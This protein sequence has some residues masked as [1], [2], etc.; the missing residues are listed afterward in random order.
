M[1][2]ETAPLIVETAEQAIAIAE[3]LMRDG[4][5]KYAWAVVLT[6]NAP[7][8]AT[9]NREVTPSV[10]SVYVEYPASVKSF[11]VPAMLLAFVTEW[12]LLAFF[13][14]G[15]FTGQSFHVLAGHGGYCPLALLR[16]RFL[17][18]L[19]HVTRRLRWLPKSR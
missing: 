16:D 3:S 10:P 17:H 18:F 13:A 12:I 7:M 14:L 11:F 19:C 1:L 8:V 6:A 9:L 5:T 4:V 15:G 2:N